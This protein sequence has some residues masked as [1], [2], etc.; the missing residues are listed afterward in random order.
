MY[1]LEHVPAT[2]TNIIF[3]LVIMQNNEDFEESKDDAE[4]G[5]SLLSKVIIALYTN[6]LLGQK[7]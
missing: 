7:C 1:I 5:A 6:I 2:Q 3:M 4:L